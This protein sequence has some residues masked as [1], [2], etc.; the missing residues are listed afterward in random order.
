MANPNRAMANLPKR[1][2]EQIL[3]SDAVYGY[4]WRSEEDAERVRDQL[5]ADGFDAKLTRRSLWHWDYSRSFKT[6]K[7]TG[8]EYNVWRRDRVTS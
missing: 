8:T 3:N 7:Y 2:F 4:D 6:K 5:R 1:P